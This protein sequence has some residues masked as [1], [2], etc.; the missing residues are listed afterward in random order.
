MMSETD[1]RLSILDIGTRWNGISPEVA[2]Q[3]VMELSQT[4]DKLGY[5]RYWFAEH[6]NT[7]DQT[8]SSPEM[9]AAL[10]AA[11]TKHIR[12]GTGGIM[13][14]NHSALKVAES[15]S[16]LETLY[17]QRVDL[18]IGR[19]P[20]TDGNTALALR[21]SLKAVQYDDFPEQLEELLSYFSSGF[22]EDHPFSQI[23]L[24]PPITS[25]PE[26]YMLG[27]SDGG[28]RFASK[29]GL[30]FTFAA[31]IS[32]DYAVPVLRMYHNQ[33]Q[34]SIFMP[35]PKSIISIM[36]I[37]AET[38][39]EANYLAGPLEL[40]WMRW[41]TGVFQLPPPT[42]EEASSYRYSPQEEAVR[43]SNKGRFIVGRTDQ[44]AERL[45]RLAKDTLSD[46]V[47]I[48]QMVPDMDA[49]KH[50]MELLAVEFDLC[51]RSL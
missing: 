36:A 42:L 48:L 17:P 51:E 13:L 47:M 23:K 11:L 32:P 3:H 28:M 10:A 1:I 34:P 37:A 40:Q 46:E 41:N 45:R 20:G 18:G 25:F 19:A 7:P 9:L 14:P 26:I 38:E 49:R 50:S 16:T 35:Q 24:T 8:S 44:V 27:S 31:H 22:S 29:Y 39:E 30:G 21:R 4:A 33:F 15:F 43:R 2:L 5:T 12:V 6:H